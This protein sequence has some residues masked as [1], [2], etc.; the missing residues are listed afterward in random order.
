MN[1][2]EAWSLLTIR[3]KAFSLQSK[4]HGATTSSDIAALLAGLPREPFLMGMAAECGDLGALQDIELVLWVRAKAIADREDWDTPRGHF[5]V[6]RMVGVALYEAMEDYRCYGCN[7]T[8]SMVF[9]LRDYP[10]MMMAPTFE[11]TGPTTGKV[12]CVCCQSSGSVRLSG[13]KKADLAGINKDTW[14][15]LWARRYESVFQIARDW[16]QSA[17]NH[18]A[19]RIRDEKDE[20]DKEGVA[21]EA[22]Q[23]GS[24]EKK[25]MPIKDSCTV[26][27]LRARKHPRITAPKGN[28]A[29]AELDFGAFQRAIL[30]LSR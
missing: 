20:V 30:R 8:G 22:F 7:G 16:R 1:P 13:R 6:R 11:V 5:T 10:A 12:R 3:S 21:H 26:T 25:S 18:L 19:S 17:K 9:D 4:G 27:K 23:I 28:V 29:P 14:T 2:S 15:R 24:E